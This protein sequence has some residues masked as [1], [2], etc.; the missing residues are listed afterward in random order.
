MYDVFYFRVNLISTRNMIEIVS[1]LYL[2]PIL[3]VDQ[4][5][6]SDQKVYN[7]VH[8]ITRQIIRKIDEPLIISPI[9]RIKYF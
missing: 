2:Y 6:N 7:L 4:K 3:M 8:P 9:D 1:N 5:T